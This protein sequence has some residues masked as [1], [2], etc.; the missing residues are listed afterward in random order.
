MLLPLIAVLRREKTSPM[1]DCGRPHRPAAVSFRIPT[2]INTKM[3]IALCDVSQTEAND[4]GWS[5][6][7]QP[8]TQRR[9][10]AIKLADFLN[11]V[12]RVTSAA[13]MGVVR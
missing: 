8:A 1:T 2:T 5:K 6:E 12:A 10:T 3:E 7:I 9:R 13:V 11:R 4:V